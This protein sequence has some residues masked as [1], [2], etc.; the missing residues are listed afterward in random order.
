LAA[1]KFLFYLIAL[2]NSRKLSESSG[3]APAWTIGVRAVY[4]GAFRGWN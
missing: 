1:P 3:P 4:P 2:I